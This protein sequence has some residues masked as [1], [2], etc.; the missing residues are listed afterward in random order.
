MNKRIKR[1]KISS[2]ETLVGNV[3]HSGKK[4]VTAAVLDENGEEYS[5]DLPRATFRDAGIDTTPGVTFQMEVEYYDDGTER[6]RIKPYEKL[7]VT[8]EDHAYI[9]EIIRDL[10]A[11]EKISKNRQ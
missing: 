7:P 11:Q 5:I 6:K 3:Q 4:Y 1:N 8:P 9:D 10:E 2:I